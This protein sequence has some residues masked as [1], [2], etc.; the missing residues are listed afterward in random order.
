MDEEVQPPK[1]PNDFLFLA[2]RLWGRDE[3]ART[4]FPGV[5]LKVIGYAY[6]S[7]S[8]LLIL[9]GY[10]NTRPFTFG[11]TLL[12]IG[13]VI[14]AANVYTARNMR[15]DRD[16]EIL[17][18]LGITVERN[19]KPVGWLSWSRIKI[20]LGWE[21]PPA[22]MTLSRGGTPFLSIDQ[23]LAGSVPTVRPLGDNASIQKEQQLSLASLDV[24]P[25][26]EAGRL[27]PDRVDGPV[28]GRL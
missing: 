16:R 8:F 14:W 13:S 22:V 21:A 9:Y 19:E 27:A 23:G 4:G 6:V 7:L 12:A 26:V 1:P 10:Q 3:V 18:E 5:V 28:T 24:M 2:G 25:P 17:R 11:T 20:K 15:R